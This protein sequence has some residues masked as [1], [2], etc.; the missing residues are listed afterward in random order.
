MNTLTSNI[1]DIALIFE[2]GGMRNSYS[3]GAV[4]VMLENSILFSSVYGLSA[5]ATNAVNYVSRDMWRSRVSFTE[6]TDDFDI[7]GLFRPLAQTK[8]SEASKGRTAYGKNAERTARKSLGHAAQEPGVRTSRE[9]KEHAAHSKPG[10]HIPFDFE[11]FEANP[12]RLVLSALERDSG[13]THY[14]DRDVFISEDMLMACVRASTSYPMLMPPTTIEGTAYYDG[15]IGE[16]GGI[17]LS[18]A[19]RDG[20]E[21]F[22][23][24]CT[25][26]KGFRKPLKRNLLYDLFFWRR[27]HMRHALDTWAVRYNAELDKLEALE[28]QGRAYVFY[29]TDQSVSNSERSV[30]RL[31]ENYQKGYAQA[32]SELDAWRA[33]IEGKG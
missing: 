12:A 28:A 4:N 7:R 5:G 8:D 33:F 15:G 32:L 2:G 1:H 10:M 31:K 20:F 29:A 22:F 11:S 25:R 18:R 17:M 26:P 24:V 23:V 9:P 14:F 30:A 3:S 27:P 16:G 6:Y 21:R 13:K 19:E